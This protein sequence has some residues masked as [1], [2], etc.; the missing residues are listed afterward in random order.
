MLPC[1]EFLQKHQIDETLFR[2]TGLKWD[3]LEAIHADHDS[4]EAG[5]S[6]VANYFREL[7][8]QLPSVHSLKTRIKDPDHLIE[9]IIRKRVDEPNR[10]VSIKNYR[11]EITD[12]VGVRALHLFKDDWPHIHDAITS[13]RLK[14]KPVANIRKGDINEAFRKAG[15]RIKEHPAGYRS[16]HYVVKHQSGKQV[17]YVEIQVRTIFEEGWSEIDH[18]VRYPSKVANEILSKFLAIFNGL[19]GSADH[20]G[21]YIKFLANEIHSFEQD[22]KAQRTEQATL[23][24]EIDA[25]R[26][27]IETL[28]LSAPKKLK[29]AGQL[30]SIEK[31]IPLID[32]KT[33]A[34]LAAWA[35]RLSEEFSEHTRRAIE[36]PGLAEAQ[37]MQRALSEAIERAYVTLPPSPLEIGRK[38]KK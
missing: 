36:F 2:G 20:M 21:S 30:Q 16:V 10:H 33:S 1:A 13:W 35:R 11:Q 18:R 32:T 14:E 17:D 3:E 22:Q 12:L 37:S 31:H 23:R 15:C 6:P 38:P 27:E 26:Q 9:K 5:L 34:S 25:L 7:L 24:S 19:A 29:I 4:R 8:Q 28:R